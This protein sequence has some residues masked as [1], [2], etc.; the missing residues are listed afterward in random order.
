MRD[1]DS[2]GVASRIIQSG[3]LIMEYVE[4]QLSLLDD[5]TLDTLLQSAPSLHRIFTSQPEILSLLQASISNPAVLM[6]VFS[7]PDPISHLC[8]ASDDDYRLMFQLPPDANITAIRGALCSLNVSLLEQ[9]IINLYD[10]NAVIRKLES[11]MNGTE[12]LA[13]IQWSD[14][15]RAGNNIANKINDLIRQP[16]DTAI[17]TDALQ[18]TLQNLYSKLDITNASTII[19]AFNKI[20]SLIG[21]PEIGTMVDSYLSIFSAILDYSLDLLDKLTMNYGYLDISSLFKDSTNLQNLLTLTFSLEPDVVT[22][23]LGSSVKFEKVSVS[24]NF[25]GHLFSII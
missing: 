11:I 7:K 17:D 6:E 20:L 24:I 16:Y 13:Q 25:V 8:K 22:A 2:T 21:G 9:D 23:I 18:S 14:L 19:S 5:L 4:G 15:M 1:T 3:M 12:P 10:L